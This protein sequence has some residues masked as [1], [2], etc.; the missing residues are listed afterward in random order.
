MAGSLALARLGYRE[1]SDGALTE[2]L[3]TSF[4]TEP[5]LCR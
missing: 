1:A 3:G 4:I 5:V 2:H